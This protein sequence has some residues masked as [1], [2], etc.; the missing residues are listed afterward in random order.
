MRSRGQPLP[1]KGRIYWYVCDVLCCTS[2]YTGHE[3]ARCQLFFLLV[4]GKANKITNMHFPPTI[5]CYSSFCVRTPTYQYQLTFF[6]KFGQQGWFFHG[7]LDRFCLGWSRSSNTTS[8]NNN[9]TVGHLVGQVNWKP[10]PP[11]PTIQ[12]EYTQRPRILIL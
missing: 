9:N 12:A 10:L 6:P 7:F 4:S 3:G 1:K 11:S 8:N 5:F 2:F